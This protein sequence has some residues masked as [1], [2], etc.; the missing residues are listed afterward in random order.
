[1]SLTD[2]L[3]FRP[4]QAEKLF[5]PQGLSS[6]R[7]TL[8]MTS[9]L[10]LFVYITAHLVN[11]ALG[12]V[13]LSAAEEGLSLAIEVWYSLPGTILLYG[14]AAVHFVLALWAVYERR[15]FRLPPA[16]LLRIA[17]GFTLPVI[18]INHFANTRLAYDLFGLSSD[19]TRVI[20]NL[21]IADSQ[22]MQLGL[23]A[24]GWLHGCLGLHFAFNRKPLYRRLRLPLFAIALLLPVF[25]AFGFIAMGKELSTNAAA[26][27]AARDYLGPAHA[28]ERA[29]IA[30]WHNQLVIGYFAI[31]GATFGLRSIRNL[32]ERSRKRLISISYPGRTVRVPR[33]WSILEASRGFH[34]PHAS[35]CGGRARCSTCRVRVTAG[36]DF[37][38]A[39]GLD[40]EAT[41]KRIGAPSDVRLACQLRPFGD[42]SVLPLV[43]TAR[44][45]YRPATAQ[46]STERDIVVMYC[47][48]INGSDL[49]RDQ[50][51][52]DLLYLLTLYG[53]AISD[54]IRSAGGIVS[55]V[56]PDGISAIFVFERDPAYGA[57]RALQAATAIDQVIRDLEARLGRQ[58]SRGLNVAVSIHAGRAAVGEVG[59]GDPPVLVAVGE[60]MDIAKQL[61]KA[62]IAHGKRFGISEPVAQAAGVTMAGGDNIVLQPSRVASSVAATI[63]DEAP[64]LP[65]AQRQLAER[66]ASLRRMWSG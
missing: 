59:S 25:S 14:A 47:D 1:M 53:E 41:L 2:R 60:A 49:A 43:Q 61:R 3:N 58:G 34:L 21:W 65:A 5:S 63:S 19:Y 22:G 40:E 38:P 6:L 45:V 39:P 56:S 7:R 27:A 10:V 24:P 11:H 44:P 50:L 33:G 66:A 55:S 57:R 32:L 54:C 16:E 18:L 15:T 64:V 51:P 26:A 23:L 9:G 12:L 30:R 36:D 62:V 20:A 8:R 29:G 37:C 4:L 28:E 35:M 31:I 52:Q 42:I 46:R 17:L 48:F 13:S